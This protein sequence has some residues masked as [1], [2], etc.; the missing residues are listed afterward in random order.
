MNLPENGIVHTEK[1]TWVTPE[2][3]LIS[4]DGI[5]SGPPVNTETTFTPG[6]TGANS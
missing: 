6:A 2:I 3:E 4:S 5:L 1:R